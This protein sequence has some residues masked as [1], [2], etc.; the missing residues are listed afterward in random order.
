MISVR[1]ATSEADI[2]RVFPVM[3]ELRPHLRDLADF[4][5]RARRQQEQ[6]GW[7]LIYAENDGVPVAAAGFRISEWLAWSKTLYIDDLICLE[8]HRGKGFAKALLAWMEDLARREGCAALHLDSGTHRTR[9]HHFYFRNGL[10][11]ASFHFSK[12]L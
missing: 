11:I 10:S 4:L 3:R 8:S 1:T 12:P 9:A 6:A 2:T 7:R 5:A